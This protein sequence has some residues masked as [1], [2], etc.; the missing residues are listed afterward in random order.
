MRLNV[1][2]RLRHF[3]ADGLDLAAL[4]LPQ[5]WDVPSLKRKA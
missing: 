3:F 5:G 2:V 1:R 4:N